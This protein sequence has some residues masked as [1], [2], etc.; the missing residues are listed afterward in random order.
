MKGEDRRVDLRWMDVMGLE[1]LGKEGWRDGFCTVTEV[2]EFAS[3]LCLDFLEKNLFETILFALMV[4]VGN[5]LQSFTLDCS[6]YSCLRCVSVLLL[7][8]I[9]LDLARERMS[10]FSSQLRQL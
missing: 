5:A 2:L 1:R 10:F 4:S 9:S 8:S 6:I 7:N 3:F